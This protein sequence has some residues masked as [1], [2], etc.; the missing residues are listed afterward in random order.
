MIVQRRA[1][2]LLVFALFAPP[3]AQGQQANDRSITVSGEAEVRVVPDEVVLTLGVQ[4]SDRELE[5]AKAENDRRVE[6]ILNA[7]RSHGIPR[8]RL[9]TE[10]LQIEP[11]YRDAYEAFDFVGYFVQ[12][13][14]VIR[15]R[16][17]ERFESLLGS[18]LEA[19]ANFVHGIDFRTTELRRHRD[20]ARSLALQAAQ[21]KADA[22][23]AELDQTVGPPNSVR[24]D[25]YG[26]WSWYGSW[27]GARRGRP[28][29]QNVIQ[30]VG[31]APRDLGGP[32]S[33]GQ[34]SVTARVTVSFELKG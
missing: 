27:W 28:M 10:F 25:Y 11:R 2:L 18:V 22:M 21:E 9:Q 34:L 26:W 19:G 15:L 20:K 13:T 17:I 23:A 31:S 12:K 5:V 29:S 6:A 16:D 14:I 24:E 1:C 30:N 33:P 8:E 7:A 32:T 4:T 3:S